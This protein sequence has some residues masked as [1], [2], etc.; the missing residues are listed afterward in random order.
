M[1]RATAGLA[2]ILMLILSAIKAASRKAK[3][4]KNIELA[5]NT[6]NRIELRFWRI[7]YWIII[8]YM[9]GAQSWSKS[10]TLWLIF[11]VSWW[12]SLFTGT[13]KGEIVG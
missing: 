1:D 10:G 7:A 3:N 6:C 11:T 5:L 8:P 13:I 9:L 12:T 4:Y 2:L